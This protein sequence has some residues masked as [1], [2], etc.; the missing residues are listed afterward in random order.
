MWGLSGICIGCV[1]LCPKNMW[2]IY[3]KKKKKKKM[4]SNWNCLVISLDLNQSSAECGEG[5]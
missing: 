2:F 1:F 3:Q 5:S 4:L